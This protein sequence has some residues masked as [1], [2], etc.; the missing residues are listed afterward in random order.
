MANP[1]NP[2]M[3]FNASFM[4]G[5]NNPE[6]TVLTLITDGGSTP[7]IYPSYGNISALLKSGRVPLLLV[8]D[9]SRKEGTVMQLTSYSASDHAVSFASS[10]ALTNTKG[11]VF[12]VDFRP[13]MAPVVKQLVLQT[14]NI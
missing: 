8:T 6:I 4:A 11:V 14:K 1:S 5:Y 10:C 2:D 9:E 12:T 3:A 7:I 13:D